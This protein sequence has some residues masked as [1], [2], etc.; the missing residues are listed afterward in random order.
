MTEQYSKNDQFITLKEWQSK[1]DSPEREFFGCVM[2]E[3]SVKDWK[4][5]HLDGIDENDV[6]DDGTGEYGYEETPH[7]TLIYGIHE[8]E[9]DPSVIREVMEKN[10]N[11]TRVIVDRIG[12]FESEEFD[13]LKYDV[14][15]S[16]E[17]L[18]L[19]KLFLNSFE[20]T[21]TFKEY[22]PHITLSYMIKGK[23][24]KYCKELEHPF[25][26]KFTRAVYSYHN[27]V[28]GEVKNLRSVIKLKDKD[29][30]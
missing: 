7:L 11:V 25:V 30:R 26:V 15:K 19:R 5:Q 20:N 2:L 14:R 9:I 29:E 1:S 6:Y 17:L 3:A 13:V 23:A 21:Q 16:K 10:I 24:K 8:D 28:D 4:E 22:H 12:S 18:R 27:T